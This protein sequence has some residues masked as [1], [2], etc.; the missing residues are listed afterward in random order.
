[1]ARVVDGDI[2]PWKRVAA[3]GVPAFE[4]DSLKDCTLACG[5]G[6]AGGACFALYWVRGG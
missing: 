5:C 3:L 6:V 2:D 1:M 4:L